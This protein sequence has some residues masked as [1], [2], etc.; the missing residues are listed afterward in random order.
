MQRLRILIIGGGI[1]GLGAATA[2]AL[3]GF[4]VE[5]VEI[6]RDLTAAGGVGINQPANA[7]RAIREIG[8]LDQCLARG[9]QF[10]HGVHHDTTGRPTGRFDY[11]YSIDE[12]P[13]NNG[14]SRAVLHDIL[15]GAAKQAG[16]EL[17]FG[18]SVRS[19]VE[20]GDHVE[21]TTTDGRVGRYDLLVAFD[22]IGSQTR[23]EV[24]GPEY[25]PTPT[26]FGV[27]RV[28]LPRP[29]DLT[30]MYI[31]HSPDAKVGLVPVSDE[32]MYLYSVTRQPP[33]ESPTP[34]TLHH[35]LRS[36][37]APFKGLPGEV[38]DS[39]EATAAIVYSPISEVLLPLPWFRGRIAVLG[40]A[41]HACAPHLSQGAAMALEDGVVL[42]EALAE[43]NAP[44][45]DVLEEFGR[46]RFPRVRAVQDTSRHILNAEME[47]GTA[48]AIPAGEVR[49][50]HRLLGL[51]A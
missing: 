30:G 28:T 3:R 39:I 18:T 35:M 31:F 47:Q 48:A 27:L 2:L 50:I 5:L 34:N 12:V 38:R 22:G 33:E 46:R 26:G 41:A 7:L 43:R 10:D 44:L 6:R 51:P 13:A 36:Q 45:A 32:T 37:L 11:A 49:G 21:V 4:S 40:D 14:I 15:L 9:F 24:F 17:R 42:A 19:R 23:H 8:V 20:Y 16:A 25:R 29:A 1:G